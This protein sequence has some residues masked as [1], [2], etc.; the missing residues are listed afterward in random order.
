MSRAPYKFQK[1]SGLSLKCSTNNHEYIAQIVQ[2]AH[3]D[4]NKVKPESYRYEKQKLE[5]WSLRE[6]PVPFSSKIVKAKRQEE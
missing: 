4:L 6:E 5:E 2:P 3:V 1:G